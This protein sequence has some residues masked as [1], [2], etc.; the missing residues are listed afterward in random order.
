MMVDIIQEQ[1]LL[2]SFPR[3][4]LARVRKKYLGYLICE[5]IGLSILPQLLFSN[6]K[7]DI[8]KEI[9]MIRQLR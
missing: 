9:Q 2:R 4:S 5:T 7:T 6:V 1:S 8:N 3:S